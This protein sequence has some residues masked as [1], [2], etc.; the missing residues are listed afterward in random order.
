VTRLLLGE[1]GVRLDLAD[2]GALL[3][4]KLLELDCSHSDALTGDLRLLAACPA[5]QILNLGNCS[6]VRKIETHK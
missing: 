3:G 1:A 4:A 6:L 2:L 5:L